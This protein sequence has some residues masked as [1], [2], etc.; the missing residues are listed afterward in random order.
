VKVCNFDA[1][2][3]NNFLAYINYEDCTLCRKCVEV[4]PTDA[5]HEVNFKPRKPKGDKKTEEDVK[6]VVV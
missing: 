5:I 3:V 6:L 1:I 2:D 4:C